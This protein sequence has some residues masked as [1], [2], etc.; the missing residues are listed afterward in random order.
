MSNLKKISS[1]IIN[2]TDKYGKFS[3]LPLNKGQGITIGNSLRRILLSDLPGIAITAVKITGVSHEFSTIPGIREDVLEILLNLKQI[4]FNG[5]LNNKI[6]V[7]LNVAGPKIVTANDIKLPQNLQIVNPN[8][9]IGVICNNM[10]LNMEL[11]ISSGF[12]YQAVSREPIKKDLVDFIDIDAIF[13]PV[14]KVNF[15]V[16]NIYI[17]PLVLKENL[18]IEIWTNGSISPESAIKKGSETLINLFS[19]CLDSNEAPELIPVKEKVLIEELALSVRTHNC[20]KNAQIYSLEDLM[21][22]SIKDLQE[23]KN[24]GIILKN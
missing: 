5:V 7:N 20:L 22:Y 4:I 14:Q 8:Q 2:D 18:V 23:I 11:Q 12:G 10:T 9:Y 15:Y 1:N 24:F 21:Q 3:I 6:I 16:E 13:M 19:L 17:Q